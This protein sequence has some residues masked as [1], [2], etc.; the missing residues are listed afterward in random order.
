MQQ[1][2]Q[3]TRDCLE[4]SDWATRKAAADTLCVLSAHSS[5]LIGDDAAPTLSALESC[6]FDKVPLIFQLFFVG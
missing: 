1:V 3:S 5:H 4:N 6:R 2:L